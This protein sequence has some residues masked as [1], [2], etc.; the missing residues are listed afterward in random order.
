MA[1]IKSELFFLNNNITFLRISDLG[2]YCKL[3]LTYFS[4]IDKIILNKNP[5]L[6]IPIGHRYIKNIFDTIYLYTY[7]YI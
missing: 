4:L 6:N 5:H 7:V 3:Y 2:I 1:N